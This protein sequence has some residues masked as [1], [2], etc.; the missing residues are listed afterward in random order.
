MIY[1]IDKV[2]SMIKEN[3][4]SNNTET[5]I[6]VDSFD[7]LAIYEQ[8]AKNIS[9][10]C[11]SKGYTLN[12][13]LGRKKWLEL[14]K[15]SNVDSKIINS[16]KNNGWISEKE[17]ITYYRNLHNVNVLVLM[18][19]E[20]EDDTGGL[21]NIYAINPNRLCDE[22]QDNYHELF[23]NRTN[24]DNDNIVDKLFKNLFEF[25]AK[26]IIK[27]SDMIDDW[28]SNEKISDINAFVKTFFDDLPRWNLPTRKAKIPDIKKIE[29]A[30]KNILRDEYNFITRSTFSQSSDYT[31]Y[32]SK[33]TK[34]EDSEQPYNAYWEGWSATVFGSYKNFVKDIL[35][36]IR[37][38][39][40]NKIK[41]KLLYFDYAIID[42]IFNFK[43][44]TISKSKAVPNYLG[45]PLKAFLEI[46]FNYL[47]VAKDEVDLNMSDVAS[48]CVVFKGAEVVSECNS[49][50][51]SS[52]TSATKDFDSEEYLAIAWKEI[53]I[54]TNGVF[55]YI[56]DKT[57]F[58]WNDD[59]KIEFKLISPT[60]LDIFNP[61][62]TTN[63]I[64]SGYIKPA[65]SNKK[66]TKI[67]FYIELRDEN[68]NE[69]AL[70]DDFTWSIDP[71][72][73]WLNNYNVYLEK[74]DFVSNQSILPIFYT[75]NLNKL[76]L[77]KSEKEFFN[78]LSETNL[79]Y[80]DLIAS[81]E[82][83]ESQN[84]KIMSL[85]VKL[86][87]DFSSFIESVINDGFYKTIL[88]NKHLDLINSYSGENGLG[89]YLK[90]NNLSEIDYIYLKSFIF[91][92]TI[93]D[94]SEKYILFDVTI[95]RCIIPAWHPA[96]IQKIVNQKIF[97]LDGCSEWFSKNRDSSNFNKKQIR[98][99]LDELVQ[100]SII[101]NT[102]DILPE[103]ETVY[104]GNIAAYG[105]YSIYSVKDLNIKPKWK[106]LVKKE[107]IYEDDFDNKQEFFDMSDDAKM[108]YD[109]LTKY[110][111]AF[112]YSL[113]NL[114]LAFIEPDNLQPIVTAIYQFITD[115]Q[116]NNPD[117]MINIQIKILVKPEHKGGRNYL[118]Y[119][120]DE[121]F[122]QDENVNI[123]CYLNEW[124]N[125][126]N[127]LEV[128]NN[129]NDI[130]F[131]MNMLS[132]DSYTFSINPINEQVGLSDCFFPMVYKPSPVSKGS[133]SRMIEISQ[134]QFSAAYMHTQVVRRLNQQPTTEF[135]PAIKK[136]KLNDEAFET[137]KSLHS[138][139]YWVVC[140]D[141]V[142][143]GGLLRSKDKDDTYSII[144]FSTGKG[145]YG[146]YNLTITTRK[147]I[148]EII[149][150]K[151]KRRLQ[152]VFKWN[153]D[154]TNLAV[155]KCMSIA[156]DIDGVSLLS[157]I[158]PNDYKINEFLA[159]ILTALYE[160]KQSNQAPLKILINIDS[161]SHWFFDDKE[162]QS[163]PDFLLLEVDDFNGEKI[164]LKGTIIECK[165]AIY[166]DA[167]VHIDKA[168]EQVK[169]G[170]SRLKEIF[171]PL[172]K[173]VRRRY[174][175]SQLYRALAFAQITFSSASQDYQKLASKLRNILEGD[176]TITWSGRIMGYWVDLDGKDIESRE[177]DG[178]IINSF[179]QIVI[180][181][182]LLDSTNNAYIP[183]VN[184]GEEEP[185]I[186]D[187]FESNDD[188]QSSA[189]D[190]KESK[191][192]L[193]D[194][195]D[196]AKNPT[197]G[198][199]GGTSSSNDIE[200]KEDKGELDLSKVRV[201]LGNSEFNK[202]IYW[203]FGNPSLANRHLLITG[204][205]GTGKTY[206]IQ[207]MLYELSKTGISAVIFD[208]TSGFTLEQLE[209]E[210]KEQLGNHIKMHIPY[211]NPIPINPFDIH[212]IALTES[213]K[214][215]EKKSGIADRLASI[216]Q[217]VYKFG[218]QQYSSIYQAIMNGFNKHGK[219]NMQ[220]FKEEIE[221]AKDSHSKMVCKK[222]TPFFDNI[223]FTNDSN[224]DWN[225]IIYNNKSWLTIF[226][227]VGLSTEIQIIV[228]E[229]LLWDLW[230]YAQK[231][232]NKNKPFVVVLDEAQNLSHK[233][234][235]PSAKIL[236]E[237]RK[238]GWSAWFA[239]QSL[240]VLNDDEITRLSQ[241]AEKLYFKPTSEEL[242]KISKIIDTTNYQNY[243]NSLKNL[244]KGQCIVV[245]DRLLENGKYTASNPVITSISSFAERKN[246]KN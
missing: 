200:H 80:F 109:V 207:T 79:N 110:N 196:E 208:Y 107:V 204:T 211:A 90:N 58:A 186:Y 1:I 161:Y 77:A 114:T 237:G 180:Q 89:N 156:K 182:L 242:L 86:G 183:N 215:P 20:D 240:N 2:C 51:T 50:D 125:Y 3:I 168:K 152:Y 81:L 83:Q 21:A 32:K 84:P 136:V 103:N 36:Y 206:S 19:T 46:Y 181:N 144:G 226:Q 147:T 57:S 10:Y 59:S 40:I 82:K 56:N 69:L 151:L 217:H 146:K 216:F 91:A 94:N 102:I 173:S 244:K 95:D 61:K 218:A 67:R 191:P 202:K 138:K 74:S 174:W 54:A 93:L 187:E 159:Y 26:D 98:K 245:G 201:L 104:Y 222:M 241:A 126:K 192:V 87:C 25:V 92:F 225:E 42:N 30:K 175:F 88:N 224:L 53:C 96:A 137:I 198:E 243:L 130:I 141:S 31:K 8:I 158:N 139:A 178:I 108:I 239:T 27:L 13:K 229:I 235:S 134:P 101:Q 48:F 41:S 184:F 153:D 220:Y 194:S 5:L 133:I 171:N 219:M 9:E 188:N 12:I 129:N 128:L 121:F 123:R 195:N 105:T 246:E 78:S 169:H 38:E 165:T 49:I 234:N 124:E 236:T 143:D 177:E 140:I 230:Y 7:N 97:L 162:N 232:G 4:S 65:S 28:I 189:D 209:P 150:S 221:S 37:G 99:A 214:M 15:T 231:N 166:N 164:S 11:K 167:S 120:M 64:D 117:A 145:A 118:A 44:K 75:N 233:N 60:G 85:F 22:L 179:P 73:S 39:D 210:F 76:I 119:W 199:N 193:G 23:K 148:I 112:P 203:E 116:A 68:D 113:V 228:T 115:Y 185:K 43:A 127:L 34:Y 213:I 16:L 197:L 70:S 6:R 106:D 33:L 14:V 157:A 155:K 170:I 47:A 24:F 66:L 212:E 172:S 238:F 122:S 149:Q 131:V 55:E 132:E 52:Q 17:S 190:G 100:L 62:N 135:Y 223:S 163:R 176:F 205:S 111:N 227:L 154:V 35:S 63:Y 72:S 71:E 29:T 160:R 45:E 142:M 18:G